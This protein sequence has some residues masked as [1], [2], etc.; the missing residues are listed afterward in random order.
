MREIEVKLQLKHPH[1]WKNALCYI[2]TNYQVMNKKNWHLQ[3]IYFDTIDFALK[4]RAKAIY[5]HR[6]ENG[7]WVATIKTGNHREGNIST[8][9]EHNFNILPQAEPVACLPE[10]DLKSRLLIALRGQKVFPLIKTNVRRY[11]VKVSFKETEIEVAFDKG[12]VS[13][14]SEKDYF[15]EIEFELLSGKEE[16]LIEFVEDFSENN[17]VQASTFSKYTRGLRLLR[18]G[19]DQRQNGV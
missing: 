3:A 11:A 8:R 12:Y 1:K 10:G 14:G 16:E 6:I 15:M 13:V 19:K 18:L 2:E 4:D 17:E 7:K 5:R 9:E